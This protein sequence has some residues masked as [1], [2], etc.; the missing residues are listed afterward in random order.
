MTEL[1]KQGS[2]PV[3]Q[4][5]KI[6][7]VEEVKLIRNKKWTQLKMMLENAFLHL[8]DSFATTVVEVLEYHSHS[9]FLNNT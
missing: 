9:R 6:M 4:A 3:K 5:T 1:Q 8:L 2:R 7:C